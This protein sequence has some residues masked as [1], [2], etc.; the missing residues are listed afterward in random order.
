MKGFLLIL[1]TIFCLLPNQ[2]SASI[3]QKVSR[4][5]AKDVIQLYFNFDEAPVFS[6]N[7]DKRRIDLIF[8][9]TTKADDFELFAEDDRIVKILSR[10]VREKLIL[11]L[12]FRY[13]PQN[14]S[15]ILSPDMT[16]V[17]EVLLGNEY[18]RAYQDLADRLQGLTVVD[19]RAP[20]FSNPFI[21]SPYRQDWHSFF[22]DYEPPIDLSIDVQF[23][24][25]PFPLVALLPPGLEGNKALFS[26]DTL[27][28]AEKGLWNQV[29]SSILEKVQNT[30]DLKTQKLLALSYG[31]ALLHAG[32]FPGAF[33]QLYLLKEEF[34]EERLSIYSEY[35]LILLRAINEDV[36][37]GE[38]D[39]RQLNGAI[40]HNS[41]LAPYFHL[42]R[43]EASLA[44]GQLKTMN[45]LL[46][47]DDIA[48]PPEIEER[49]R[50]READYWATMDQTIK[51]YASFQLLE[52]STLLKSQP[53]SFNNF[54]DTLYRRARYEKAAECFRELG[55]IMTDK[56]VEGMINYRRQ[57]A[58]LKTED[59]ATLVDDFSLLENTNLDTEAGY[60]A[61]IKKNDILFL[62]DDDWS[63]EI[64]KAY[65]LI[66]EQASSRRV[67]EEARFKE[68]LIHRLQ[69]RTS[70]AMAMV[71]DFLREFRTGAIRTSAQALL[72]ELLPS[73][74]KRKVDEGEYLEAL[75]LAKKNR[76]L[77]EKNWLSS[78]FLIDIARAY[79]QIGIYD[80][81]QKL[82]LYLIEIT[83]IDE[84]EEF[85]LPMIQATYDHG[86]YSL[87]EDYATQYTYNYPNGRFSG[88]ISFIRLQALIADQRLQEALQLL[89]TPLPMDQAYHRLA[90]HL[91][92]RL[93]KFD[94]ALEALRF[95]DGEDSLTELE[96]FLLAESLYQVGE[97]TEASLLFTSL[98]EENPYFEQ[99]LYRQAQ[100]AD[101][102]GNAFQAENLYRQLAES[103]KKTRWVQLA[104]R[105]LQYRKTRDLF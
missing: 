26:S 65:R 62:Y 24:L 48:L 11:S 96:S 39:L 95:L 22:S 85:Y 93:G 83:P 105:E 19:R 69:G 59:S 1:I 70:K 78:E 54:C 51:A 42:S 20:D 4:V 88:E 57:M 7:A 71:Q 38:Y 63:D 32:D 84:R 34:Q 94:E 2:L 80:E 91:F 77:F 87:V 55:K 43:I 75:V 15:L 97:K 50:I 21:I 53:Y 100:I 12:F 13:A 45:Q 6:S 81:A 35:L 14:H 44:A 58:R 23:T 72:I 90:G 31:E 33:T 29:A 5:D 41:P 25:P 74:I 66:A 61:A 103:G 89:P 17:F 102:N 9:K 18:S 40:D 16:I 8:D 82:Y 10:E 99:A 30:T 27:A 60:L 49:V 3:L 37:L 47:R 101:E 28:M 36:H 68:I 76:D 86:N 52:D 98:D 46:L 67:R 92:F 64:A 104:E 56:E 79:H 73:E